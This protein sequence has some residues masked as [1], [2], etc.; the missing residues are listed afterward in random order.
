MGNDDL[1]S[2]P[3]EGRRITATDVLISEGRR[4]EDDD[5][6]GPPGSDMRIMAALIQR[7][8]ARLEEATVP[9]GWRVTEMAREDEAF[10]EQRKRLGHSIPVWRAFQCPQDGVVGCIGDFPTAREAMAA[11]DGEETK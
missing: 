10:V 11:L 6:W 4:Y 1:V 2:K 9:E 8:T 7:L 3:Q 5:R